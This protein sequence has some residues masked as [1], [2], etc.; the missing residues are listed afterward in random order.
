MH[1]FH[2]TRGKRHALPHLAALCLATGVTLLFASSATASVFIGD[3]VYCDQN[4]DGVFNAGDEP[5][6]GIEVTVTCTDSTGA[7]CAT[8]TTNTGEVH[9]SVNVFSFQDTCADVATWN[10]FFDG[11][12]DGRYLVEVLG[13]GSDLDNECGGDDPFVCAAEVTGPLPD[14]CNVLVT[15][16]AGGTPADGN[17][18]DAFCTAGDDGP[19]PEGQI[20]G[21]NGVDEAACLADA[22]FKP[23]P[24]DGVHYTREAGAGE[25]RCALYADFGYTPEDKPEPPS[26]ITRTL[27]FWKT[28]PLV[29]DNFLPVSF[30]GEEVTEVCDAVALLQ[31]G[32][33][34]LGNFTRQSVAASLNCTAFGCSGEIAALI[35]E[36]NAAC[37][38]GDYFDFGDAGEV[39]DYFNNSGKDLPLPFPSGSADPHFCSDGNG[40]GKKNKK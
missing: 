2:L 33:G 10:P 39:L 11:P 8:R 30:C 28:H 21:G 36:G 4:A 26:G 20:L 3:L 31:T 40:N 27:G 32:G 23:A 14:D 15:P 22:G 7:V 34:G 35:A 9:P 29:L 13:D 16:T 24:G 37:A 12:A 1:K 38:A 17:G 18:D 19:F 25:D 6:T 5:L